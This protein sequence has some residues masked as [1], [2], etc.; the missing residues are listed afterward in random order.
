ME[1]RASAAT[2]AAH[3]RAGRS[4]MLTNDGHHVVDWLGM[5]GG[6][7]IGILTEQGTSEGKA[8]R[9]EGEGGE[10]SGG[11]VRNVAT[12]GTFYA[13]RSS[14][15]EAGMSF[16]VYASLSRNSFQS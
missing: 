2:T 12:R 9:E 16:A 6:D 14:E 5:G 3:T 11:K 7:G 4:R 8:E 13:A 1:Q 10:G 15:P